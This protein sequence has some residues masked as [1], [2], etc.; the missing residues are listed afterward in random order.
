MQMPLNEQTVMQLAQKAELYKT[1]AAKAEAMVKEIEAELEAVVFDPGD[2]TPRGG[3]QRH[4]DQLVG[5]LR[6][7][8]LRVV[9][10]DAV[11]SAGGQPW[12]QGDG[13]GSVRAQGPYVARDLRDR[14]FRDVDPTGV[15][16]EPELP[17]PGWRPV[18]D[19]S[20]VERA[21][22]IGRRAVGAAARL[23]SRWF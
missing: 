4:V 11:A 20:K 18:A 19:L 1:E 17:R 9:P 8:I 21:S 6:A 22:L 16:A 14:A 12:G 13:P 15:E 10:G 7:D 2:G 3:S 23:V 5:V